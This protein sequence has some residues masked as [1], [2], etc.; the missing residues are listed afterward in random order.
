MDFQQEIKDYKKLLYRV[1]KKPKAAS[2]HQLRTQIHRVLVALEVSS[3]S[4]GHKIP[5][6]LIK[7][8]NA[9]KKEMGALRDLQVEFEFVKKLPSPS[10]ASFEKYLKSRSKVR[11]QKAVR[12][13][14]SIPLKKH[15]AIL[16][17]NTSVKP[18]QI[19]N[20]ESFIRREAK[21]FARKAKTKS[22]R[23]P[24]GYHQLRKQAKHL[25]YL[26]EAQKSINGKTLVKVP[27]LKTIQKRLGRL[28]N[29]NALLKEIGKYA[30]NELRGISGLRS[31]LIS[32]Q[33]KLLRL[34]AR[35]TY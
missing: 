1:M 24:K 8:L 7:Q 14:K 12:N 25:R 5:K 33:Q 13:I 22:K 4:S 9:I 21:S 23:T 6:K 16:K 18:V 2:V 28:Q 11:A 17:K 34:A 3:A 27:K 35:M 15:F 29:D 32:D 31:K 20:I 10:L 19:S 30:G 26:G